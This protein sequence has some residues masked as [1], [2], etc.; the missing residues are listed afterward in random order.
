MTRDEPSG[1][2]TRED[3]I[4]SR[5]SYD[6]GTL[7]WREVSDQL[8]RESRLI[9]GVGALEQHGP[10]LPLGTNT[11]IADA[12]C[13]DLSRKLEILRAPTFPYGVAL[14]GA[15]A[16]AGTASLRRKTLH[17]AINELIAAWEDHGVSEFVMVTAHRY[18][19]HL[20]ALLMAL[21]NTSTPT[22]IDVYAIDVSDLLE[23]THEGEH[24]G[25]VETSLLLH[26]APEHVRLDLL[27]DFVP[28]PETYRKYIR[29]R[30]PTPPPGSQGT[31][32]RPSLATPTKGQRIYERY[33]EEIRAT[34]AP[35]DGEGPAGG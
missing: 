19:P 13:R 34:L 3:G 9:L 20:D 25:E 30:V 4:G 6:L 17:R 24:G 33:V 5:R 12:I 16:F 11:I 21:T 10:H 31:V 28:N 7:T 1:S 26:L 22:V 14:P 23:G 15:E 18:E 27:Q 29:G 2:R 8:R 32:G 35:E